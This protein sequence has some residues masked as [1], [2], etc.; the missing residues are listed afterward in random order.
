MTEQLYLLFTVGNFYFLLLWT[1]DFKLR[2]LIYSSVFLA[3]GTG[4]RY[5]AWSVL[6]GTFVIVGIISYFNKKSIIKNLAIYSA[7]PFLVILWW[8][9][10]NYIFYGD[11][12][13]FSR[14]R[15]S[16]L[17]QLT[18]YEEAGRL[19]T[20]NNFLLSSKVY[21]YS[22]L[23][24]SGNFYFFLG[25]AGLVYYFI[26]NRFDTKSFVPYALLI[27]LP[28]SLILLYKGQVIIEHPSSEPEGY[29]NSRYGLY[30]FPAVAIFAGYSVLL[31][32]KIKWKKILIILLFAGIMIQ[33]LTFLYNF[34]YSIPALAEAKYSYSQASVDL[35]L[36]LKD[37]YEGG[38]ILYDNTVF[39]LHPWTG[40]NLRN[41]IT[42]HTPYFGELV[43]KNPSY[44]VEWIIFYI[45]SPDKIRDAMKGNR[46]FENNFELKFSERGIEVYKKR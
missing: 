45:E 31:I 41:R 12:L 35:S 37:N 16:T 27:A 29:F 24:Y 9:L 34:P 26:R 28:T 14:G 13:E 6:A 23:Y 15:F 43:M 21:L 42:F 10:H 30:L 22:V 4:S 3:L 2:Y 32:K 25:L 11:P 19:L 36:Y 7:L 44:Y 40:I 38:K 8:F 5:D 46:N 17:H 1:K 18:Y 33:Q 39:A 20:K